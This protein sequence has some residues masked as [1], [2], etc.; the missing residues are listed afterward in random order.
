MKGDINIKLLPS[1][2][3]QYGGSFA[4]LVI[5]AMLIGLYYVL[6]GLYNALCGGLYDVH[7]Q[8]PFVDLGD[9][10]QA[11]VCCRHGVNV[12]IPSACLNGGVF[13]YSP[14]LLNVAR[15]PITLGDRAIGGLLLA[16]SF[17]ASLA[18]LPAARS[19]PELL[20]RCVAYISTTVFYAIEQGNLDL[21]LFAVTV[22]GLW[23]ICKNSKLSLIGYVLFGVAAAA[24][25]YP[26]ILF[27]LGLRERVTRLILLGLS[28][29]I[30]GV[31]VVAAY[32]S[33]LLKIFSIIPIS[34]P[35]RATFGASDL[36][37]GLA[38]LHIW[39]WQSATHVIRPFYPSVTLLSVQQGSVF[40]TLLMSLGALAW[41]WKDSTYY[42]S[43]MSRISSQ[44]MVFLI[45]GALIIVFCFFIT[46]NVYYR[47]IFLLM[48][49]PGFWG[50]AF[51][52]KESRD[53]RAILL[54]TLIMALLWEATIRAIVHEIAA[55]LLPA[56]AGEA[57]MVIVWVARELAWWWLI[58]QLLALII[59]YFRHEII[60]LRAEARL[61]LK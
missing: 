39:P 43:V 14:I 34:Q 30:M 17:I 52:R 18:L 54:L 6:P 12:Y 44:R 4:V 31:V 21:G 33:G 7:E 1:K 2:I 27:F 47:G 37:S 16:V 57:A 24:K 50:L 56:W 8:V 40:F 53:R 45:A 49:V 38:L 11:G 19:Y 10:L 22:L 28:G 26:A 60:R 58:I 9:I 32:G 51:P 61:W 59:L 36:F 13:N 20:Y 15:L 46:Q 48:V 25:F 29:C 35:F 41:A 55:V 3:L 23:Y 5:L 42:S